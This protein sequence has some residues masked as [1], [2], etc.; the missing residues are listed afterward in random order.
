MPFELALTLFSLSLANPLELGAQIDLPVH[1][2]AQADAA[3]PVVAA[4]EATTASASDL[5]AVRSPARVLPGAMAVESADGSFSATLGSREVSLGDLNACCAP[6][7]RIEPLPRPN[8]S[9]WRQTRADRVCD[10]FSRAGEHGSPRQAARCTLTY[11]YRSR[12]L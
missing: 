11:I 8:P 1:L 10:R 2:L 3:V 12:A 6:C 5:T 9:T 4:V 7:T